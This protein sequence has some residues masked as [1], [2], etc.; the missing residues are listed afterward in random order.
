MQ[1][2]TLLYAEQHQRRKS[3]YAAVG[4][5]RC[6]EKGQDQKADIGTGREA[7]KGAEG[8]GRAD[9][10]DARL[11]PGHGIVVKHM[12]KTIARQKGGRRMD[13]V[14]LARTGSSK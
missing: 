8:G 14:F 1:S 2:K 4:M 13:P 3:G 10:T 9:C 11:C 12:C 5:F 6:G 7:G